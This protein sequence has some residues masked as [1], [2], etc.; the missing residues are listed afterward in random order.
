MF[1]VALTVGNREE[2]A[3][4]HVDRP[5]QA[6][7]RI[8]DG[9]NDFRPERHRLSLAE[10]FGA[11]GL[12]PAIGIA[13]WSLIQ[14]VA[15]STRYFCLSTVKFPVKR[16]RGGVYFGALSDEHKR[17]TTAIRAPAAAIRLL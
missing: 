7:D 16:Y 3:S 15:I 6:T 12:D 4:V 9:V 2:V 14:P 1:R 11:G 17:F 8:A 13:R 10:R 5:R